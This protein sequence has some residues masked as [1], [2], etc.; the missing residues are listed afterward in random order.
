MD[1]LN[2]WYRYVDS[3][4]RR[5]RRDA[6]PDERDAASR[7]RPW[8]A[9]AEQDEPV[10]AVRPAVLPNLAPSLGSVGVFETRQQAARGFEDLTV[11]D[12]LPP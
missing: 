6:E 12:E 5:P 10:Q 7:W 2:D 9:E 1:N 11:H 4:S 8:L 3:V